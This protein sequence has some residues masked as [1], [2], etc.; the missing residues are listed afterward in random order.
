MEHT[1]NLQSSPFAKIREGSKIYELRLYDEKRKSIRVGDT[2]RFRCGEDQLRVRV[3]ELLPFPTFDDLYRSL[4]L[5]QC[6]YAPE[7]LDTAS[8]KDMELY[9]SKEEQSKYGVLAIKIALI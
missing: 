9:Y 7:E 5:T 4:P 8:P 3:L 2:I 1:M 6:G